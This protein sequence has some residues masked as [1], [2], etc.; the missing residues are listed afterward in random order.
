MSKQ[1]K[2]LGLVLVICGILVGCESENQEVKELQEQV[3]KLEQ[4]LSEKEN[5]EDEK[6][7]KITKNESKKEVK[8]GFYIGKDD[9]YHCTECDAI[10]DKYDYN[11]GICSL[12]GGHY[13]D[14]NYGQC[15]DCG[16][17][18]P[19]N[20]MVDNGRSYHCGCSNEYCEDCK[21]E[22]PY[23][24]EHYVSEGTYLCDNCYTEEDMICI[25]CEQ[26]LTKDEATN[27]NG[28]LFCV[29]CYHDLFEYIKNGHVQHVEK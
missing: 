29:A 9:V 27:Q 25:N 10:A 8:K 24:Q 26:T 21:Q 2:S 16:Q 3:T 23:G 7:K 5:K 12:C 14:P 6:N 13:N 17:Y 28:N 22:I 11:N 1:I 19:I 4:Q 15:Y 20:K 18:K